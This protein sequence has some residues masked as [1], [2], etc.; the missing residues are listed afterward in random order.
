MSWDIF[1]SYAH[2]NDEPLPG[3]DEG[4]ITTFVKGL[5]TY[6]GREMGDGYIEATRSGGDEDNI[7]VKMRPERWLTT[8]YGKQFSAD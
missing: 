6:L 1:I 7:L 4:W 5:K 2:V 8:D 3:V